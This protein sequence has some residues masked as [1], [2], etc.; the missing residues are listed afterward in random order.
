M[1]GGWGI[2]YEIALRWMPLDLTDDK[3]TL[4]QVM[5]WCRQATS[6]YLSQYWPRSMPPNGVTISM[7]FKSTGSCKKTVLISI[8]IANCLSFIPANH[9]CRSPTRHP[10]CHISAGLLRVRQCQRPL[11]SVRHADSITYSSRPGKRGA[12]PI[13]IMGKS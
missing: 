4:V 13:V 6:H 10:Q 2:S 12:S 1:N 9:R 8:F 7:S 3:S 5:A 11:Q